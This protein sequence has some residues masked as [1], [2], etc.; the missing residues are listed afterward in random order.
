MERGRAYGPSEPLLQ[1]HDGYEVEIRNRFVCLPLAPARCLFAPCLSLSMY[2]LHVLQPQLLAASKAI[3]TLGIAKQHNM[4]L[5]LLTIY[6][7]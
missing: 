3:L 5:Y 6:R 4:L 7:P 2:P 1:P